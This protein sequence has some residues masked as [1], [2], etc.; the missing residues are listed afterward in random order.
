M[1]GICGI[2]ALTGAL[3]GDRAAGRG[4]RMMAALAHRGPDCAGQSAEETAVLGATRLAIRGIEDGRQP[5]TDPAHGLIGVC[6]GEI[7]N[8]RELRAWLAARGRPVDQATDVAVI[9]PLYLELGDAFVERL[10]GAFAVAV[11]DRGQRRLLLAR[12]RAG[13][14]PLFFRSQNGEAGFATELAALAADDTVPLNRAVENLQWYLRFGCFAAPRTPFAGVEK[15]APGEVVT[16]TAQG[17]Q[18]RRYWRW[19]IG[20]APAVGRPSLDAFDGIFRESVRRQSD[21]DVEY[22]VFLSGGIDSSLIAAVVKDLRPGRRLRAYTLR[23]RE[24]SY[25]EGTAADHV[26]RHLGLESATVWVDAPSFAREMATLVSLVGEPLADPAWIP[27]ALLARRAAQEVKL[28]LVGEGGDEL[29]GGYP[30]YF[31]SELAEWYGRWPR[32]ARRGFGKFIDLLPASEKK[33]TVSFLLKRFIQAAELGGLERHRVWTSSIPPR[34]L[35]RLIGRAVDADGAAP[36]AGLLLD[37]LQQYDLETTLAEGLL[38]K[39]DRASMQSALEVRAPFLDVAVMEFAGRL[40]AR[41]RV[42]GL[43]TKVFLKRYAERYLP[44]SVV[45]RRKRGL[46]V[47]LA[48]WLRGPL[49]EWAESR[50]DSDRL[51]DAGVDRAAA[52]ELLRDHCRPGPDHA[53]A[54]W[55]LL[56]LSE[57]L[58]WAAHHRGRAPQGK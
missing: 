58:E 46:S 53:R 11:W 45:H 49:R 38:T 8:H 24:D 43:Q 30:T 40:P 2:V 55:T 31:G 23:F 35:E 15:V 57:W 39:A 32:W 26:A 44:R 25:D 16:V 37:V 47:P 13:E 21:V 7:D 52:V 9:L 42:R 5:M 10:V 50:L 3:D 22:G 34:L 6:N 19:N 14:R 27:T 56:V 17:A 28:V 20:A 48:G 29:F 54:L 1:C 33:V 4:E 18:R 41:D 36:A 12:D 51:A